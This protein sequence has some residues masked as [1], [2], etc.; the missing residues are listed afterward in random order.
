M[1]N[2]APL[3]ITINNPAHWLDLCKQ[4]DKLAEAAST[5]SDFT[6]RDIDEQRAVIETDLAQKFHQLLT[7]ASLNTQEAS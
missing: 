4:M 6:L 2:N 5:A 1:N 7:N 3:T